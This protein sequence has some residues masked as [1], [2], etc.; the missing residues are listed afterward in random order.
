MKPVVHVVM[1][2]KSKKSIRIAGMFEPPLAPPLCEG[3]LAR[4]SISVGP[5]PDSGTKVPCFASGL[6]EPIADV[7]IEYVANGAQG[8]VAVS[9]ADEDRRRAH[10]CLEMARTFGD[11]N[12][13]E[14]L[15]YMAQAWLRL[16][17]RPDNSTLPTAFEQ[18]PLAVEQQQQVQ[19]EKDKGE[20]K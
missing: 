6:L 11:R 13:R 12:A 4:Q 10:Q 15:A 9:K 2:R 1:Q 5:M 14:T 3:S 18:A 20:G 19:P 16:A 17:E 8:S 7:C